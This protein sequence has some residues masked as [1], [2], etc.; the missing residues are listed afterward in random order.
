MEGDLWGHGRG[1]LAETPCGPGEL[2]SVQ[3]LSPGS[4]AYKSSQTHSR[5]C[6]WGVWESRA[7]LGLW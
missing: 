1:H 6:L 4:Q 3:G 2:S 5:G 7:T